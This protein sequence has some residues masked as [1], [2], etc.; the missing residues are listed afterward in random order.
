MLDPIRTDTFPVADPAR[1]KN[2]APPCAFLRPGVALRQVIARSQP[3]LGSAPRSCDPED[4]PGWLEWYDDGF[5]R[6]RARS[7]TAMGKARSKC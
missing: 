2:T 1:P 6:N 5:E 4:R 3:T 7:L